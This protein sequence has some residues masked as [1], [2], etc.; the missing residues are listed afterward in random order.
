MC[1]DD[2]IE[3][4]DN[5]SP[6]ETGHTTEEPSRGLAPYE[7]REGD[8]NR[9]DPAASIDRS[10]PTDVERDFA[11]ETRSKRAGCSRSGDRSGVAKAF[12]ETVA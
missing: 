8:G 9:R 4:T 12:Y 5:D 7:L 2:C 6:R 11:G 3:T 10:V 1:L